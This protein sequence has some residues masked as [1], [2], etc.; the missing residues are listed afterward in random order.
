MI[1]DYKMGPNTQELLKVYD[2]Y[3]IPE[4]TKIIGEIIQNANKHN[5]KITKTKV[6]YMNRMIISFIVGFYLVIVTNLS[7]VMF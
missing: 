2:C 5:D 4:V 1:R 6:L 7:V 3:E